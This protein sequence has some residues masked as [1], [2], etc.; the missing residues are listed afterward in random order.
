MEERKERH[1]T[2]ALEVI[3]HRHGKVELLN[4]VLRDAVGAGHV[5]GDGQ[6][7]ADEARVGG[8]VQVAD[9]GAGAVSVDLVDGHGDLAARPYLGHGVLGERGLGA[10]SHVDVAG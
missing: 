4:L 10:F 3:G 9:V 5:V 6:V 1:T 8:L 7:L 2:S